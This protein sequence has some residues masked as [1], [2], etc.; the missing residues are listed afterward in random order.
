MTVRTVYNPPFLDQAYTLA[1]GQSITQQQS[2]STTTTMHYSTPGIPD[3][4]QTGSYSSSNTIKYVSQEQVTVPAG[5]FA[6]CKY[7]YSTPGQNDL[8]TSWYVVGK[9][10]M[11]KNESVIPGYGTM[12][13]QATSAT[14]NGSPL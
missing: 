11:V 10:V 13:M 3:N 2:A 4:T 14:I 8:T 1:M 12:T 5:T 7:E 6:A 9:G